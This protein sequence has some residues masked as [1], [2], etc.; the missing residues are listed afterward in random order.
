MRLTWAVRGRRR[1]NRTTSGQ[2]LLEA[3]GIADYRTESDG[4]LGKQEDRARTMTTRTRLAAGLWLLLA[5][6]CLAARPVSSTVSLDPSKTHQTFTG[7]EAAILP[8]VHDYTDDLPAFG[9]LFTQAAQD[10]G[11]TRLRVDVPSGMEGRPG[12]GARYLSRAITEGQLFNQYA[13]NIVNDNNDPNVANL[14][15]FDFTLLNWQMEHLVVPYK[16]HLEAAGG[17]LYFY[18]TYVD[19]EP[20]RFKHHDHPEEYA[21]FMLVLFDHLKAA[22]GFAPD[23][24]DVMNEPDQTPWTGTKMGRVIVA[25]A[26]RLAAAGYHPEFIAPSTVD[27]GRAVEFLDAILD[28]RG[29][30]RYVKQLSYHCYADSGTNS[31]DAIARRA[32]KAGIDTAQNEC[33]EARNDYHA[34]HRDLKIG[35]TS[36]WQQGTLNGRGYYSVDRNSGRVTLNPK[37]KLMRQ[38]YKYIRPGAVRIEATTS[39]PAMDPLAFINADGRYVA[40]I[41]AEAPGT[42]SI[43]HLPAG[44]YGITYSTE[45]QFDVHLPDV[46]IKGG[47]P[48]TTSIPAAGV[49]TVHA[50]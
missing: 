37:T 43:D 44:V 32:I 27:R 28:V 6:S 15:A 19:F 9:S 8:S 1:G 2:G 5:V 22:A 12:F 24:I 48:L 25:T 23:G 34:L 31:L 14:A 46:D 45:T 3:L 17:K 26:A 49:M 18:L 41:L 35:R 11:I 40:V 47:Q 42:V 7:W 13:Y 16:R 39:E 20:S 29:A 36:A 50:K 38:Y 30:A 10:L 33:W 4:L 21:E